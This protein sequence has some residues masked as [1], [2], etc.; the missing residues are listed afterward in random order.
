MKKGYDEL[1]CQLP[2]QITFSDSSSQRNYYFFFY[3]VP[4]KRIEGIP[5]TSLLAVLEDSKPH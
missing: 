1:I 3:F 4:P 2:L 5:A